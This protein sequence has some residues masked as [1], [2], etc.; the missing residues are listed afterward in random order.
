[1]ILFVLFSDSWIYLKDKDSFS[2]V[3]AVP[4]CRGNHITAEILAVV[5]LS[6]PFSSASNPTDEEINVHKGCLVL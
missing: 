2:F 4:I 3:V 1:M 5:L 6:G